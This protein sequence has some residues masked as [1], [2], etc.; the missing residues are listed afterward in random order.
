M[1]LLLLI[2]RKNGENSV[3]LYTGIQAGRKSGCACMEKW[4]GGVY[5]P[6]VD[7][8]HR[9]ETALNDFISHNNKQSFYLKLAY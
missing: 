1:V 9:I 7:Y 3:C 8:K 6:R 2:A 4:E 5:I